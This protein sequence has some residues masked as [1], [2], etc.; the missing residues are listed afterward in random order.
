MVSEG[1]GRWS[2]DR[3]LTCW[4]GATDSM[5]LELP[6]IQTVGRFRLTAYL[7]RGQGYGTVQAFLDGTPIGG[8]FDGDAPFA[9]PSG[10]IPLGTVSL[11]KGS[12]RLEFKVV[13]TNPASRSVI[14]GIDALT[15][16]P[17]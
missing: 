14:V 15:L 7:S 8:P 10:P 11:A 16:T 4:L 2:G 12:H 1:T 17:G 5:K 6:P 3:Q 13:G 9:M